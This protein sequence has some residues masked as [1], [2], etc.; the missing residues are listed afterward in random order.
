MPFVELTFFEGRSIEEKRELVKSVTDAVSKSL[1]LPPDAI[2]V[3]LREMKKDQ[4][5][6]GGSLRSDKP[7]QKP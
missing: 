7:A 5:A 3:I 2:H 6:V 1:H 4:W